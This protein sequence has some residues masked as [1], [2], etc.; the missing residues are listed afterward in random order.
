MHIQIVTALIA[1]LLVA[2][3]KQ[4]HRLNYTLWHCLAL[5]AATLFEPPIID[6]SPPRTR[7]RRTRAL[8]TTQQGVPQ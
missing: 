6:T 1:Y 2:L 7:P 4:A 8:V 3:Y 5:I